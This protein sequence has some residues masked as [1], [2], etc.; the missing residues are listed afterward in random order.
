MK[1][2]F[3]CWGCNRKKDFYE[4]R[5]W[6]FPNKGETQQYCR[7]CFK[8]PVDVADVYWDG[9]PEINLADDPQ[10]GQ[11][12]VFLSKGQKAAYLKEKGLSEA[13]DSVHGAPVMLHVEQSRKKDT[14][15]EVKMAL[16][17]VK[18]MGRDRRRFEYQRIMKENQN[19]KR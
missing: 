1:W 18:E 4:C 8:R 13:G 16:K 14:R 15:H 12:R 2:P 7:D 9:K 10:T 19:A 11:P 5:Y 17:Q 3:V 6:I